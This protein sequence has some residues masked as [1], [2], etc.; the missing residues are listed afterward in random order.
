[1][2]QRVALIGYPLK[3]RHSVIMHNAAFDHF[4][5]D[6]MYELREMARDGVPSFVREARGD[7]WLGFQ[8][9]APYKQI[10]M[11]HLDEIESGAKQIGAVNS[12]LRREDGTLVGFNTDAPG[13]QRAAEGELNVQFSGLRV[14]V[15]GA[16]G[17]AR[18]VVHA[19]VTARA[20][21]VAVCDLEPSRAEDLATGFGDDVRAA[22]VGDEFEEELRQ[23]AFAVNATTVGMLQPGVAFDPSVL[24]D[25]AAVFDLVYNPPE[26]E[27]LRRVR[28]RG[29]PASNGLGMLIAQ[30]EIA[31][32]RW[33][34]ESGAGPIMRTALAAEPESGQLGG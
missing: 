23:V 21:S 27:L 30:A 13:F 12:V 6:A 2:T 3:R 24:Q 18:A 31:F 9:T 33:T 11:E 16:G 19:L 26:T 1:M 4:S 32:E 28:A 17:V 25:S 34:G 7:E 14:A 10:V 15:A 22:A 5:I 29:L 8:V 20:E